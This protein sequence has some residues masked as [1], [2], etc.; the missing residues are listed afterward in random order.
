MKVLQQRGRW[1][2]SASIQQLG[3]YLTNTVLDLWVLYLLASWPLDLRCSPAAASFGKFTAVTS[4][5]VWVTQV[6]CPYRHLCCAIIIIV[7]VNRSRPAVLPHC[8]GLCRCNRLY[9]DDT[10]VSTSMSLMCHHM[11]ACVRRYF[12]RQ[13]LVP[14]WWPESCWLLGFLSGEE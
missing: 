7:T 13:V 3:S 4:S 8:T 5:S 10:V 9:N 11:T 14:G 2:P 1:W 6:L 12:G